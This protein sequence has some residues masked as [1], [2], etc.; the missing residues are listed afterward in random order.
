MKLKGLKQ[1]KCEKTMTTFIV[2]VNCPFKYCLWFN[3][4]GVFMNVT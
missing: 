2:V 3:S 1:V 4:A